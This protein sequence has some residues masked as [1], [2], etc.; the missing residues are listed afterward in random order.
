MRV[1][2]AGATGVI[3]G[4]LVPLLTSVGHEVTALA[5]SA[6]RAGAAR[7]AGARIAVADALDRTALDRAVREAAPDAVVNMLTAIPAALDPRRLA[8]QFAQ[9]NR[10]RT[11]GT[12]NLYE[13]AGARRVRAGGLAAGAPGRAGPPSRPRSGAGAGAGEAVP[14][15]APDH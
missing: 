14:R 8:R 2:V 11:E 12:R 5:R 1:L 13:A 15:L 7:A 9:T 4:P 10:L 6:D 3:G